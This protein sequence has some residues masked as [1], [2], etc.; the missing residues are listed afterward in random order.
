M[1]GQSS[2]VPVSIRAATNKQSSQLASRMAEQSSKSHQLRDDVA[3]ILDF[4]ETN[5]RTSSRRLTAM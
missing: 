3:N 1:A 2:P 4:V 5:W